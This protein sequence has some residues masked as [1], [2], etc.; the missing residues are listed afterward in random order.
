MNVY[1]FWT[2]PYEMSATQKESL[3]TLSNTQC[4][5]WLITPHNIDQFIIENHPLHEKYSSLSEIH[6]AEYLMVYFMHFYG[7]GYTDIQPINKSWIE[8]FSKLYSSHAWINGYLQPDGT[9]GSDAY[10]CKPN[11]PLTLEWYGD[12]IRS[13]DS[14]LDVHSTFYKLCMKY[15][16]KILYSIPMQQTSLKITTL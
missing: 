3:K 9:I 7:G 10:I 13:M 1:T 4:N 5:V 11:T 8:S 15:S 14:S 2:H 16:G 6:K 12:L